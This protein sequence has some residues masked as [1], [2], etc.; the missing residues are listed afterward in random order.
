MSNP[1]C[2]SINRCLP[3]FAK[4]E[5]SHSSLRLEI[6]PYMFAYACAMA[7]T[8]N[9]MK[10]A[11]PAPLTF[12]DWEGTLTDWEPPSSCNAITKAYEYTYWVD[13]SGTTTATRKPYYTNA[14]AGYWDG[15][16]MECMPSDGWWG[17][18]GNP[19]FYY[20][21]SCPSEYVSQ[22]INIPHAASCELRA[23]S[24]CNSWTSW[25]TR[26]TFT[27]AWWSTSSERS[28]FSTT[29]LTFT[30]ALCCPEVHL[31]LQPYSSFSR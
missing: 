4:L 9:I 1:V 10:R 11:V 20:P 28:F 13:S 3:R 15:P 26:T 19:N 5:V 24:H 18:V 27:S 16:A 14:I 7:M 31:P 29:T 25:T 23:D 22:S 21:A 6:Q 2:A 8:T 30:D 17:R 12:R